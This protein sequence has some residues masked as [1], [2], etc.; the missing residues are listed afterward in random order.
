MALGGL[1]EVGSAHKYRTRHSV[2]LILFVESIGI[3]EKKGQE[4][5]R[6]LRASAA[7]MALCRLCFEG[8]L[9]VDVC[10]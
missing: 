8:L 10:E 9:N 6:S 7:G 2:V 1:A 5:G 4:A 3:P